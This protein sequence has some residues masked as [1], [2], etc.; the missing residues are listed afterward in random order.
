VCT[1]GNGGH[2]GDSSDQDSDDSSVVLDIVQ[3]HNVVKC[4]VRIRVQDSTYVVVLLDK[5]PSN[6]RLGPRV[7]RA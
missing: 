2:S 5:T 6:I 7:R 4:R 3:I 1:Q